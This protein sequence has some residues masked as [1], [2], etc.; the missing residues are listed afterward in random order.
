MI[1]GLAA[2][3]SAQESEVALA[4]HRLHATLDG[5]FA[6][7]AEELVLETTG[8]QH[9]AA[10]FSLAVPHDSELVALE[11]CQAG[12]CRE[13]RP[14]T[15]ANEVFRAAQYGLHPAGT[16]PLVLAERAASQ[17]R[18]QVAGL[19]PGRAEIRVVWTAPT[20]MLEG[21]ERAHLPAR[22]DP[23]EITLASAHLT[24]LSID[25]DPTRTTSRAGEAF[26]LMGV[27]AATAPSVEI[28][29]IGDGAGW[30]RVVAPAQPTSARDVVVLLDLSPSARERAELPA[31]LRALLDAIPDGSQV[32]LI[33]FGRRARTLARGP[34][35]SLRRNPYALP[36]DLGAST[37]LSAAVAELDALPAQE[38]QGTSAPTLVW[39]GDGG[40]GWGRA[41]REAQATL[42]RRGALRVVFDGEPTDPSTVRVDPIVDPR[43]ARGTLAGL[44]A[45]TIDVTVADRTVRVPSG[46]ARLVPLRDVASAAGPQT[47]FSSVPFEAARGLVRASLGWGRS[48]ALLTLDPRDRHAANKTARGELGIFVA[49]GGLQG[50]G[51][52]IILCSCLGGDPSGYPSVEV[53]GRMMRTLE[54][55]VRACFA[56]ARHGDPRRELRATF[57]IGLG[58]DE[59]GDADVETDDPSLRSCLLD[60]LDALVVP[61]L[62]LG[63]GQRVL[64]RYPFGS[65]AV[66]TLAPAPLDAEV[67]S[68]LDASFG[69]EPSVP[70]MTL[71]SVI[72]ETNDASR[73][74]AGAS[75]R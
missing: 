44:F 27:S 61:S 21:I 10:R 73:A 62:G 64:V 46:Q 39:L 25:G 56:D 31:A 70:P 30:A 65:P 59:L 22:P 68:S 3:A 60:T 13:A 2:P 9:R 57:V 69:D 18:L 5:G 11:A 36:A 58:D 63:P 51:R 17:L 55:P 23:V 52:V 40:L 32:T 14:V 48:R 67:A 1:V 66:Q 34:V 7:V 19:E 28:G 33:G 49:G 45:D 35:E 53:L 43:G 41:E 42:A 4:R 12:V 24:E 75:D 50:G 71:L 29:R 72:S 26:D 74:W 8:P 37:S 47:V 54:A 16:A 20:E 38:A 15:E 6:I